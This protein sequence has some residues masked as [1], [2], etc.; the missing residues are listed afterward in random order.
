LPGSYKSVAEG[1][2]DEVEILVEGGLEEG[3]V[4]EESTFRGHLQEMLD[5]Y[6]IGTGLNYHYNKYRIKN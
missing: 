5:K 2:F 4:I 1:A 3:L 6:S